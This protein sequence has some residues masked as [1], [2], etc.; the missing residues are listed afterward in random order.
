MVFVYLHQVEFY[1]RHRYRMYR[2]FVP[3]T[4][5]MFR[6]IFAAFR[7]SS[8]FSRMIGRPILKLIFKKCCHR[9]TLMRGKVRTS[10]AD[11]DAL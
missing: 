6:V 11:L 5:S 10:I 4:P 7:F 2:R 1:C 8:P 3:H 9:L